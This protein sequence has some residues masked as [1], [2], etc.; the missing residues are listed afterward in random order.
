MKI[1][2]LNGKKNEFE[3]M[4]LN[5]RSSFLFIL[6]YQMLLLFSRDADPDPVRSTRNFSDLDPLKT[7]RDPDLN[8]LFS[9]SCSFSYRFDQ[10]I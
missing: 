7:A 2:R 9:C 5:M 10:I 6:N 4:S 3:V 1:V 8:N